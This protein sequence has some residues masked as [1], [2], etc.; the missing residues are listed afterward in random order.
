MTPLMRLTPSP[1]RAAAPMATRRQACR[2]SAPVRAWL[3]A[4]ALAGAVLSV[5]SL[6]ARD[7]ARPE[8][9]RAQTAAAPSGATLYRTYCAVCHGPDAHGR[10]PLAS[11]LRVAP[12]DLTQLARRSGGTFPRLAVTRSIDGRDTV[13]GHGT[14]D[15][16]VWGDAFERTTEAGPDAVRARIEALVTY[17]AS[18]QEPR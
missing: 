14:G 11:S 8:E 10:G 13:R 1:G 12:T 2:A 3:A 7:P 4:L 5:G 6:E 17:L 15:M 16:P 18:V 9:A